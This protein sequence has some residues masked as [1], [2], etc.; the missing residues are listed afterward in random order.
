[1]RVEL[2]PAERSG[3]GVN[4]WDFACWIAWVRD[5][6]GSGGAMEIERPVE[7]SGSS[8]VGKAS[9]SEVTL[10][11]DFERDKEG[12]LLRGREANAEVED[13]RNG[14]GL[15]GFLEM[16]EVDAAE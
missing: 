6:N 13:R 3:M 9:L 7:D 16:R 8:S 1:M 14:G 12:G 15:R 4:I 11:S 2:M 5:G 10:G